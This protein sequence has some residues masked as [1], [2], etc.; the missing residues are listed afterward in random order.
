MMAQYTSSMHHIQQD[1]IPSM[2]GLLD[3]IKNLVLWLKL[4][5]FTQVK[6]ELH[7]WSKKSLFETKRIHN[8]LKRI[9]DETLIF[10]CQK[11]QYFCQ[12]ICYLK[13]ALF[14]KSFCCVFSLKDV[15][16]KLRLNRLFFILKEVLFQR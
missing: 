14:P 12:H 4:D 10:E 6:T 2:I 15:V 5:F 7:L 13:I 11:C 1:S 16:G 9:K 8:F 3:L